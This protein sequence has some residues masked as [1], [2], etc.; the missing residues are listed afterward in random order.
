MNPSADEL[1]AIPALASLST[2][3]LHEARPYFGLRWY[4]KGAIVVN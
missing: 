3:E 2:D 1:G 4:A